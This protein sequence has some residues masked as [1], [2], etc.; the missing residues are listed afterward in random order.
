MNQLSDDALKTLCNLTSIS[1]GEY[2]TKTQMIADLSSSSKL[3]GAIIVRSRYDLS[4]QGENLLDYFNGDIDFQAGMTL[5]DTLQ[6]EGLLHDDK[7]RP[8]VYQGVVGSV[9]RNKIEL[10]YVTEPHEILDDALDYIV[11]PSSEYEGDLPPIDYS[12]IN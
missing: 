4:N 1:Y 6:Y 12:I 8:F 7:D 11:D 3:I 2:K 9:S 5:R 10:V